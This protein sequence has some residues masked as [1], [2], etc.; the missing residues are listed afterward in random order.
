MPSLDTV[1]LDIHTNTPFKVRDYLAIRE[2]D[3]NF[4]AAHRYTEAGGT[5]L[6]WMPLHDDDDATDNL[7]PLMAKTIKGE[8]STGVNASQK[9]DVPLA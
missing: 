5:V 2:G 9:A 7:F 4:L 3:L 1:L 8:L 6:D